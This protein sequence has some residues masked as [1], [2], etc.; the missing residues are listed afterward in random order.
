LERD[1]SYLIHRSFSWVILG[2]SILGW[3]LV[4]RSGPAGRVA[5][6]VLAVVFAQMALGLIMAQFEI[7]PTVQVLHLGLSGILLALTTVWWCGTWRLAGQ[8]GGA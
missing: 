1:W 2:A 3:R 7:H 4:R 6:G 5:N 8:A